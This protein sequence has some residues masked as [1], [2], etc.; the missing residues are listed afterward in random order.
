MAV[1]ISLQCMAGA[2]ITACIFPGNLLPQ[3]IFVTEMVVK[4]LPV[5]LWAWLSSVSLVESLYFSPIHKW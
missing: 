4:S 2:P 1:T 3:N 5:C